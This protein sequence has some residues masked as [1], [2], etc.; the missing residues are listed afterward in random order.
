MRSS[1]GELGNPGE[2]SIFVLHVD[3]KPQFGDLVATYL[4]ILDDD[5]T[6]IT[7]TNARDGL[8]RIAD[9]SIDCVVSDYDMP[10]M[11]GIE[12]LQAVRENYPNC[13]FILFTGN[14]SEELASKAIDAGATSYL[15]KGFGGSEVFERLVNRIQNAVSHRRSERRAKIAQDRLLE[16]YEQTGGFFIIDDEW[17]ITYW[18]QQMV[19]R[20]G[21]T[22]DEVLG[23]SFLDAFPNA[24]GTDLYEK[25]RE[26]MESRETISFE[27]YYDPHEYWITVYA[28]PVEEGLFVHSREFT[29]EKEREL[30]RRNHILESF[31]NTVSHDLR[32][33]LNVAQ[34]RLQLA[35]KTGDFEHLEEVVQAHNRMRNLIDELLQVARGD[36]SA[37]TDVSLEEAAEQAWETVTSKETDLVTED[38]AEFEAYESQLRRLLEN[39]FWNALDHGEAST[40]RVG[41]TDGDEIYIEDDGVGVPPSE[42]ETI[43]ES[44]YST[45]DGNPGYGLAIVDRICE[46]HGWDIHV[47]DG[48]DSGARFVISAVEIDPEHAAKF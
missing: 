6:V 42:R 28:S 22:P 1:N 20:T 39:L 46:S 8:D 32:N 29:A 27:T 5:I 34:G 9:E 24:R 36:E 31:A 41:V 15:S 7:E 33:P 30:Q 35:Q 2:Q 25:Y 12:F 23:R 17:T 47:T 16:L 37:V 44:G 43:F 45:E 10:G 38:N 19:R 40:I 18:N 26:A 21:R 4:E 13:P 3:D 14:G 11:D 48:T